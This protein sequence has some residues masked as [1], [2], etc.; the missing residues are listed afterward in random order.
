[1]IN[2]AF[3]VFFSFV[4]AF[5]YAPGQLILLAFVILQV[6]LHQTCDFLFQFSFGN[7]PSSNRG[8]RG[9]IESTPLQA[10]CRPVSN[11]G[12]NS[13]IRCLTRIDSLAKKIKRSKSM[14]IALMADGE[15]QFALFLV[16]FRRVFESKT[17]ILLRNTHVASD[18]TMSACKSALGGWFPFWLEWD[19]PHPLRPEK[20]IIENF[21]MILETRS[22]ST[23]KIFAAA[24]YGSVAGLF[25]S[26]SR[27]AGCNANGPAW[28][29]EAS[30][31]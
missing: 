8:K 11:E 6:V 22:F 13:K 2:C 9:H 3:K 30:I 20:S 28:K 1:M 17:C 29:L 31:N 26:L 21:K 10:S 25:L 5:L 27:A 16:A 15:L 23:C 12:F 18:G 24:V 7:V 19:L 4:G 14:H